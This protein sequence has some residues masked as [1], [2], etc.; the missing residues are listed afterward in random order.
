[1]LPQLNKYAPIL[2]E[3]LQRPFRASLVACLQYRILFL[4]VF[5]FIALV[6]RCSV[7]VSHG[8]PESHCLVSRVPYSFI[9]M[10]SA[11]ATLAARP[12]P[13]YVPLISSPTASRPAPAAPPLANST[14]ALRRRG[15]GGGGGGVPV[16]EEE[17]LGDPCCRVEGNR[18]VAVRDSWLRHG[19]HVHGV[20]VV[21]TRRRIDEDSEVFILGGLS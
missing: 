7:A 9:H 18:G 10:A 2:L 11:E 14:A 15:G 20:G 17:N 6:Q 3:N 19:A 5:G 13:S 8:Q 4:G 21:A 16:F 12:A 1:M